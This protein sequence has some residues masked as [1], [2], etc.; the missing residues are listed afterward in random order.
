MEQQASQGSIAALIKK[1]SLMAVWGLLVSIVMVGLIGFYQFQ[2]HQLEDKAFQQLKSVSHAKVAHIESWIAERHSNLLTFTQSPAFIK[3]ISESRDTL[4]TDSRLQTRITTF[5]QIYG[6]EQ[7]TIV[8]E[9]GK[10]LLE[11]GTINTSLPKHTENLI[12]EAKQSLEIQ[13]QMFCY[14]GIL[15]LDIAAPILDSNSVY[16][17]SVVVHI[18]PTKFLL[19]FIDT[20]SGDATSA[21][22]KLIYP[23]GENFIQLTSSDNTL[24]YELAPLSA[25]SRD[26]F[27]TLLTT[28]PH[29]P[30]LAL[31]K[32][33][34]NNQT[35]QLVYHEHFPTLDWYLTTQI[36][37]KEVLAPLYFAFSVLTVVALTVLFLVGFVLIRILKSERLRVLSEQT[38]ASQK[39]FF[40]LF[41]NAPIAYQSLDD[42]GI[43]LN[44]NQSWCDLTGYSV[45]EVTGRPYFE[46]IASES[47]PVLKTNFPKLIENGHIENVP[48]SIHRKDGGVRLISLQG[49]ISSDLKTKQLRTHCILNDVTERLEYE[50]H[51]RLTAKVFANTGEGVMVTDD[52]KNI[53]SVNEAFTNILGYQESEVLG[54]N[55]S[56]LSSG[57]HNPD[58]YEEMWAAINQEGIWQG[59][60]WNRRKSGRLIP[61]WLTITELKNDAGQVENYIGV[62]ADITQLKDSETRLDF[63]AHHDALTE[64]PNRRRFIASLEYALV[65]AKRDQTSFAVLMLDLDRFKDVNDSYGH[66]SGDEVLINTAKL[67][68]QIV[69]DVDVVA[70]LGGDEF[71]VLLEGLSDENDAA[72]IAKKIID[73][74]SE[75]YT[76]TNQRMVSVGCS[77]GIALYPEHGETTEHLMQHADSALYLSKQRGRGTF[78]YFTKGMTELAQQRV[79][80]ESELKNAIKHRELRVFYQPQV[81]LKTGKIKGAEALVRWQ[82]PTRGLLAPGHFIDVAENSGLISDLGEW[83]LNETCRQAK[84]WHDQGHTDFVYA[85]NVSSKQL[86]YTDLLAVVKQALNKSGLPHEQLELEL[87]ESGLISLGEAA[88]G[89]FKDL[90]ALGVTIAIDDFGTGYSSL[91]YLKNLPLDILKIDKSFVDDIPN[92]EQG[93][94]IVNIIIA[95][96]KNLNLD[97]L[98]EGVEEEVQRAF[99]QSQGC[100]YYQGYLTSPPLS[101]AE[102]ETQFLTS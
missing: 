17:G 98:A 60:I 27:Y 46:F 21:K 32:T 76:L 64:L 39:Y 19:P 56:I 67:L 89:L 1:R 36:D 53:L 72:R 80:I 33:I 44:V 92:N 91:S 51:L 97:V 50:K 78:E 54:R 40:D 22:N 85:V 43:I 96:A 101:A 2:A 38:E 81:D 99:L 25:S 83:V 74:L 95:M 3:I 61:E 24:G 49:R 75:P 48:F 58:F 29:V 55:P 41:M 94:Q 26:A 69:R 52:N 37:Q 86:A 45:D 47:L 18:D 82:H 84:V 4:Q 9:L 10:V 30:G 93:M 42:Q 28:H 23:D 14:D 34:D 15:H 11:N 8:D 16:I 57:R 87:T 65:H 71:V 59:E 102:F 12:L 66:A 20:W 100:Q 77:I 90:R 62:F 5:T 63:M 35:P 31:I 73:R 70:R 88:K 13:S 6:F 68:R 7:F 79:A